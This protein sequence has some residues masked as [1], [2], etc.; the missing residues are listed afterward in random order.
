MKMAENIYQY[1]GL[2]E[3]EREERRERGE[4]EERKEERG[5]KAH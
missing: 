4:E 2:R 5:R 3:R 1:V